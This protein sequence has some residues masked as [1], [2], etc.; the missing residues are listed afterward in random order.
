VS[1]NLYKDEDFKN[2]RD[3]ITPEEGKRIAGF[4]D[5]FD[6]QRVSTSSVDNILV[7][8]EKDGLDPRRVVV[9]LSGYWKEE[10]IRNLM[11]GAP[12]IKFVHV[13]TRGFNSDASLDDA[14][15]QRC[16]FDLYTEMLLVRRITKEDIDKRNSLYRVLEF[17]LKTHSDDESD[18]FIAQYMNAIVAI[19]IAEAGKLSP[20][21]LEEALNN[22]REAA[23]FL[24]NHNLSYMPAERWRTPDYHQVALTTMSA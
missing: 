19:D 17:F 24:I 1:T 13:D 4:A 20:A 22:T 7:H 3:G 16:R 6:V 14:E 21:A 11:K 2:D 15:R 12:G 9:Q 23:A 10:D 18:T 5:R 8:I